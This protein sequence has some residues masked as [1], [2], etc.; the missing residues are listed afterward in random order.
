MTLEETISK[1][2]GMKLHSMATSL[3]ERLARNDH[4]DLAFEDM[5]ALLVDDEWLARENRKLTKRLT[6]AKFKK[7][8][9]MEDVNYQCKRGLVKSK[10]LDLTTLSWIKHHQDVVFVGPTGIGK[11]YL[12]QAL[13][14]HACTKGYTVHYLRMS[15][16][17]NQC[18]LAHA[19]GSFAHLLA[20]MVKFDVLILDDWGI[21]TLKAQ[22]RR[23]ILDLIEDRSEIR[24][25]IITTQL[26]FDHWHDFIGDETIADAICDRIIHRACKID[27]SG[28][29][30]RKDEKNDDGS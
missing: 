10:M 1:L 22:E 18:G 3:R 15:A 7:Q 17:L 28:T 26:P 2:N 29:S 9:T 4:R 20:R 24:S 23:D 8:A 25:T 13:G 19:D 27:L 5:L 14:F 21:G 6:Q 30:M 16:L 11:S 12:A